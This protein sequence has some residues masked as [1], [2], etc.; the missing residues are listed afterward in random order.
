MAHKYRITFEINEMGGSCSMHGEL[1]NACKILIWMCEGKRPLVR[2]RHRW[3]DN[4]KTN[5]KEI[6]W[7]DVD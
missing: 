6:W 4:I 3:K 7:D 1:R 2:V 5:L